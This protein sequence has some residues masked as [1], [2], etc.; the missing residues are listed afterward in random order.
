MPFLGGATC[1]PPPHFSDASAA[2]AP[3]DTIEC[4]VFVIFSSLALLKIL[5]LVAPDVLRTF[6]FQSI[7]LTRSISFSFIVYVLNLKYFP[8]SSRSIDPKHKLRLKRSCL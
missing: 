3:K 4:V 7:Y 5:S 1:T 6:F 8:K 2:Y